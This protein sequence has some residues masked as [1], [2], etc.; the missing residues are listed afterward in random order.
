M[1]IEQH[2]FDDLADRTLH[3]LENA[4]CDLDGI[5]AELQSG[6]LTIEFSDGECFVVN[7][8]GAARQIWMAAG[9]NAWHF[10]V[11]VE[12]D[13]WVAT[14]T[15]EDLWACIGRTVGEKLGRP[16]AIDSHG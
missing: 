12:N 9:A 15:G 5:E 2:T 11:D 4:L 6:V 7:S 3:S 1:S 16:I 13:R 8:H 14:R 10:D